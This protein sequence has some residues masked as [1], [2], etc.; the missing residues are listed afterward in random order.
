MPKPYPVELMSLNERAQICSV[1]LPTRGR[2]SLCTLP[3]LA[4]Y[5]LAATPVGGVD[6]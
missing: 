4:A 5:M 6:G 2:G 1:K 3:R